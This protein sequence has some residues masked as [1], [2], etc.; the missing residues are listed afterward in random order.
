VLDVHEDLISNGGI[1]DFYVVFA[2]PRRAISA[3]FVDAQEVDASERIEIV[4]PHPMA[5]VKLKGSRGELLGEAGQGFK[6]GDAKS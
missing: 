2:P 5:T 4:A 3:F 6:H 1:A